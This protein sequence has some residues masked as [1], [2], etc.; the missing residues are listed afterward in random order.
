[1]VYSLL[2]LVVLNLSS[3]FKIYPLGAGRT[4]I[5]F[6]PFLIVL[7]STIFNYIF[8]RASNNLEKYI[9][10]LFLLSY[11]FNG[12]LNQEVYYKNEDVTSIIQNIERAF[13]SKTKE[14]I[15]TSEQ[16]PSIMYYSLNLVDSITVEDEN[17]CKKKM[18]NIKNITLF[19]KERFYSNYF[20][21][22]QKVDPAFFSNKE[23][24]VI[25]GIELEGTKGMYRDIQN[26][27]LNYNFKIKTIKKYKNGLVSLS[28]NNQWAI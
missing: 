24:I 8:L 22:E 17:S 15:V 11:S 3:F 2:A 23:E 28:L 9:I 27:L 10:V 12:F 13:N 5:V 20:L 16:M 21:D 18:P 6:L 19:W 26:I 1:L 14:I 7:I 4:D 25:I